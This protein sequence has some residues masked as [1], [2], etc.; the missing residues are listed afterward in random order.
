M[1]PRSAKITRAAKIFQICV[2]IVDLKMMSWSLTQ[3]V[4][5]KAKIFIPSANLV[6]NPGSRGLPM[7]RINLI[8]RQD[9][10]SGNVIVAV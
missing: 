5:V 6:L 7:A 8:K 9:E 3:N 1:L 10:I 4:Q 2:S